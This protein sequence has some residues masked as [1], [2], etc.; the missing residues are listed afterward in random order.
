[1]KRKTYVSLA[2]LTTALAIFTLSCTQNIQ[3]A[4]HQESSADTLAVD[5]IPSIV[6]DKVSSAYPLIDS[7]K[8]REDMLALVNGDTTGTWPVDDQPIPLPGAILPQKRIIAYYGNLYSTKMGIL[9]E[10]EPEKM[11]ARL[12]EE[13]E[14][15]NRV[16]S[17]REA[18]P[19]LHYIAVV[20]QGS[21]GK[22]GKYRS[23]MPDHQI[24]SVLAIAEM[25][26][27]LVFLDIQVA[28]S[29]IQDELPHL[30]KYLK[31]PHVHLGIDPEFSMKDGTRPGKKIG[32]FTAA[33]INYASEYLSKIVQ[34][35]NLPPKVFVVHRFT[36]GMV[37]N[38]N[39][40][41]LR[42]EVQTVIHMDGWGP[43]TLKK[44][45]YRRYIYKEPVEFTGFKIFY[46]N[47]IK[48]A[49]NRLITPE[50]LMELKP[51]PVY[52][53]YQ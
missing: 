51:I 6:E 16:D 18:I 48:Q 9:G 28:L 8:F 15:W 26:D 7:V 39:D 10:Y 14:K 19:A 12:D 24:D 47:D 21:A 11:L 29:T 5:T 38:Y 27:A 33:D 36:Q 2:S 40:I 44:D 30:E 41:Q 3:G 13:I 35:N 45:T 32:H 53:Q 37:R 20:A 31:L 49:P 50:E 25:R 46:K 17:A 34:E 1:M 22:D 23:R 4:K 52:I 43:T 42:P